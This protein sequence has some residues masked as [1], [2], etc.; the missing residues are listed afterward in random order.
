MERTASAHRILRTAA[1]V[2]ANAAELQ[3]T[4]QQRRYQG[5]TAYIDMLLANGPLRE[6]LTRTRAADTYAALANPTTYAFLVE[7]RGWSP[8]ST[9]TGSPTRGQPC[10]SCAAVSSA[11]CRCCW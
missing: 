8:I 11:G 6:R 7:E 9:S 2:D 3:R 10:A 4:D 1:A 5:Q